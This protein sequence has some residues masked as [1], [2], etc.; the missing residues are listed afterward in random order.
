MKQLAARLVSRTLLVAAGLALPLPGNAIT[1][2]GLRPLMPL[3]L[4]KVEASVKNERLEVVYPN[5]RLSVYPW[6]SFLPRHLSGQMIQAERQI[7]PSGP[8]ERIAFT[9]PGETEPWL[10]IGARSRPTTPVLEGWLLEFDDGKWYVNNGTR[11][12][13]L[14]EKSR[15]NRPACIHHAGKRWQVYLLPVSSDSISRSS[16]SEQEPRVSWVALR[17]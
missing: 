1:I 2:S 10:L 16:S 8:S 3:T 6:P 5:G 12:L 14:L 7:W 11:R 15:N 4:N 13:R 17:Q 9:G